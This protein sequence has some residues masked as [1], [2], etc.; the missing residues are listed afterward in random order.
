VGI[1]G[2][3]S[4]LAIRATPLNLLLSFGLL[5]WTQQKKNSNFWLFVIAVCLLGFTIEW[6]GVNSGYIF[7]SYSYGDSLGIKWKG[8]PLV[9]GINWCII[10]YCCGIS[11]H[12]LLQRVID[13][14]SPAS[15][16][17]P[18]ILKALPIRTDGATIATIF[19][20]MMEPVAV[21]LG[22][23]KWGEDG[24]VPYY[25]YLCWFLASMLMLG[26][27][28]FCNFKKRNKFAVNLLLIQ[29]MFF[30]ILRTYLNN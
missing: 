20:W 14:L 9:I 1:L 27:F 21:K 3:E 18:Q 6:I 10:I 7:G 2:F 19:D 23:W 25:N 16:G 30:L 24:S 8:V 29:F 17:P 13:R 22:F 11:T 5:I 12:A 15:S 28:H 26:I 4:D